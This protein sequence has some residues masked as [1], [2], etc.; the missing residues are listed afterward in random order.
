MLQPGGLIHGP[1]LP[2]RGV[3]RIAEWHQELDQHYSQQARARRREEWKKMNSPLQGTSQSFEKGGRYDFSQTVKEG[4]LQPE[5]GRSPL[6]WQ[7]AEP[8]GTMQ[9]V[10]ALAQA[11]EPIGVA[12][13]E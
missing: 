8:T 7:R 12:H 10:Q 1:E 5:H 6:E 9:D 11:A 13:R 3:V 4:P 2:R